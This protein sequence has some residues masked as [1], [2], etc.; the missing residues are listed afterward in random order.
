MQMLYSTGEHPEL[1]PF[2]VVTVGTEHEQ[3]PRN[4]PKGAPFHHL[5]VVQKGSGTFQTANST[6][7]LEEGTVV[8][9]HKNTP[10]RY[11][12][13]GSCFQ[14]G[15]VTFDGPAVDDLLTY[16]HMDAF[17]VCHSQDISQQV[18]QCYHLVKRGS[19]PAELSAFLF[20][21]LIAAFTQMQHDQISPHITKAKAFLQAHYQENISVG[22]VAK[23]IGICSSL[24]YRLFRET[25]GLTP[26]SYLQNLRIQKAKQLLL[27]QPGLQIARVA[28][29]CGF[30]DCAYF[31]KVFKAREHMTPKAFQTKYAL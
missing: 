25:E 10:I 6:A 24:L 16:F 5:L 26:V 12:R 15:W 2:H 4:R 9:I 14:T 28:K 7:D 13:K 22:D 17:A 8:F 27:A 20:Q 19:D 21:I 30:E 29:A 3:E 1:L 11:F 31:C 18:R 23:G